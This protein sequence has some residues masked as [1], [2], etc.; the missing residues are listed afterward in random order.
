M[1][2][3]GPEPTGQALG[4]GMDGGGTASGIRGRRTLAETGIEG[5]R[6]EWDRVAHLHAGAGLCRLQKGHYEARAGLQVRL[7]FRPERDRLIFV[8]AGDHEQV[9]RYLR[10]V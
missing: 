2:A 4:Y 6:A 5:Q 9:K 7:I 1:L 10:G 8:F 3:A